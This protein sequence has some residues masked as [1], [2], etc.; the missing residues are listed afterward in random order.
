M[1]YRVKKTITPSLHYSTTPVLSESFKAHTQAFAFWN[2]DGA[3]LNRQSEE[4]I[5][6]DHFELAQLA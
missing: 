5:P 6:C 3:F 2:A 4:W 1:L